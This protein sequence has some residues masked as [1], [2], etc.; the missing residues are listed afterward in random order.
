MTPNKQYRLAKGFTLT[1]LLVTLVILGLI[2][3]FFIPHITNSVGEAQWNAEAENTAMRL[4]GGLED[5]K[6]KLGLLPQDLGAAKALIPRNYVGGDTSFYGTTNIMSVSDPL[7]NVYG[8]GLPAAVTLDY[9]TNQYDPED[10]C[11]TDVGNYT[12]RWKANTFTANLA[13][14]WGQSYLGDCINLIC[15]FNAKQNRRVYVALFRKSNRIITA[16]SVSPTFD[17]AVVTPNCACLTDP[18]SGSETCQ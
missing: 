15:I 3:A 18:Y 1:E 2:T 10:K 16:N 17:S 14:S 11:K 6:E 12:I 4:Y 7:G 8:A 5:A 13:P 9:M